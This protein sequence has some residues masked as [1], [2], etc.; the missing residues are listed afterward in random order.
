MICLRVNGDCGTGSGTGNGTGN[1]TGTGNGNGTGNGGS[2]LPSV[3]A[4]VGANVLDIPVSA[5]VL[6]NASAARV[7]TGPAR[8]AT[9]A[10]R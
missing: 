5:C 2:L 1:G 4:V 7:A 6:V 10:C 9:P 8:A 3:I